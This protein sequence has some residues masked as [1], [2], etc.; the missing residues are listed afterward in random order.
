MIA[1]EPLPEGVGVGAGS[2][3]VLDGGGVSVAVGV[4]VGA[5]VAN[6]IGAGVGYSP[7]AQPL[8]PCGA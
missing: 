1:D 7:S 6:V 3:G 4:S 8:A 2:V 5:I